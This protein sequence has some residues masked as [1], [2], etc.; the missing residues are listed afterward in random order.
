[1]KSDPT[2]TTEVWHVSLQCHVTGLTYDF[3]NCEGRLDMAPSSCCDMQGCIE[4]FKSI[5]PEVRLIETFAG[6]LRDTLYL[7][8][9]DS[10]WAALSPS[11]RGW[12][13]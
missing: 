13:R 2:Q 3:V 7:R 4:L 11:P 10:G 9:R 6:G 12:E 1:M 8:G 5:S